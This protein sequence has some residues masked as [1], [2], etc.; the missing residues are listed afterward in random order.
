MTATVR[1]KQPNRTIAMRAPVSW[2]YA[3]I[4]NDNSQPVTQASRNKMTVE[5]P[6]HSPLLS[7]RSIPVAKRVASKE[8]MA[9]ARMVWFV[10]QG[11]APPF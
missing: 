3:S 10:S 8:M 5:T 6:V 4:R 11:S 7:G 2:Q 9:N 1:R